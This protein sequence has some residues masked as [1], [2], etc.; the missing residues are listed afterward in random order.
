MEFNESDSYESKI[1]LYGCTDNKDIAILI[2][3]ETAKQFLNEIFVNP[4]Q[5]DYFI[6]EFPKT[7]TKTETPA[8][9]EENKFDYVAHWQSAL[10]SHEQGLAAELAKTDEMVLEEAASKFTEHRS[11]AGLDTNLDIPAVKAKLDKFVKSYLE[12]RASQIETFREAIRIDKNA[13]KSN[14][15][16]D[17]S[18]SSMRNAFDR[19]IAETA[20]QTKDY[21]SHGETVLHL[22]V[23]RPASENSEYKEYDTRSQ[24]IHI[25]VQKT[26]MISLGHDNPIDTQTSSKRSIW[27]RLSNWFRRVD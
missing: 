22:L 15:D 4:E 27:Q 6:R 5:K 9:V 17:T 19:E 11:R 23:A 13:L 10:D 7:L 21:K 1:M 12:R 25:Y 18:L 16:L 26:S 2:A 3:N 8:K 14:N 24:C 20:E